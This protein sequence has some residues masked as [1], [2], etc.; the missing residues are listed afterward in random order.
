MIAAAIRLAAVAAIAARAAA[1]EPFEIR[2]FALPGRVVQADLVDLDGD[3]RSDLLC[4][5]ADGMPPAERRTIYVFYQRPGRKFPDTADWSA[6]LPSGTAAYDLADLDAKPG[7]ELILLRRDRLTLLSLS[8]R[9]PAFR[10]L[11]VGPEPTIAVVEDEGGVD[12]LAIARAGLADEPRLLVPGL[13]ATTVLAPPGETLG[14][15]DVG[16]RANYYLPRRPGPLVSESE[17]EIYFDHP[18]LSVGDVDGDGRGDIVSAN[19]HELRVFAQDAHG[20]F[21]EHATRRIALGLLAP[22]DHVR[23][24]G[25]VRV[26]GV[27]L[28]GDH[29]LDLL[30]A[31][32]V[33]SLFSATTQTTVSIHLNR[34]GSW[35]LAQ[36]DQQF[37][38]E[39]GLT[40]NVVIDLDGDGRDELIETRVPTGVLQVVEMLVTRAIDAEVKI[41]RRGTGPAF[42]AKP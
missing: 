38:T 30:I 11:A 7:A 26:D 25:M 37:Q 31:K 9:T 13:G 2:T 39:G 29:R 15:L 40:G 8:G 12:R 20:R 1:V 21:P 36:P 10:D 3:G 42:E 6:P 19:R 23:N 32:S 17:V 27:D 14:R 28:D 24:S 34:N 18:R 16:A 35:N 22:E 5:N 41:Y 4:M 33:G